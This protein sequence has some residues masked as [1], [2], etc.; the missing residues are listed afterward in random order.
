MNAIKHLTVPVTELEPRDRS[1]MLSLML[2]YY[3]GVKPD[4]FFGDLAEKEHVMVLRDNCES[5]RIVG[6]STLMRLRLNVGGVPVVAVFS[7]D[8]VVE[9]QKRNNL[10]FVYEVTRYFV[11][12]QSEFDGYKVAWLLITKGWRTYRIMPFLFRQFSPRY[13][14][15]TSL[16]HQQ[17]I[18][19][20]GATRYPHEYDPSNGLIVFDGDSQRI[21]PGSSE[22]TCSIRRDS[23]VDYFLQRNPNYLRGNELVCVADIEDG[24]FTTAFRKA[25]CH[26]QEEVV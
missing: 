2:Q 24:N 23:H 22:D 14:Q 9:C 1:Q 26:R 19:A 8:T 18:D 10:G 25:L 6:F 12:T 20:F 21:R 16:W 4:T 5:G 15:P 3:D 17:V 7:G 13:D 11:Q